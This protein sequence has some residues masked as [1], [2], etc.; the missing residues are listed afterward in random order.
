MNMHIEM[1]VITI[2]VGMLM[3]NNIYT[4]N[5]QIYIKKL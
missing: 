4:I 3:L 5:V 1:M 2:M